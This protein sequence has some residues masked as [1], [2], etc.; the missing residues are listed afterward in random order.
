MTFSAG[1]VAYGIADT[2]VPASVGG[3]LV[4]LAAATM[5][6]LAKMRAWA[7]DTSAERR[8]LDEAIQQATDERTRYIA[9]QSAQEEEHRRRLRD[10]E[11]DRARVQHQLTAAK[12]ALDEQF[13]ARREKL[14]V[15][16]METAIRL[17]LAGLL[18]APAETPDATILHLP[19]KQPVRERATAHPADPQLVR[20]REARHP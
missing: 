20:E 9:A 11:A 15:S 16:S 3:G 12:A 5:M 10:L 19:G 2:S 18:D 4:G 7:V 17:H 14:I 13:E 6:A 8:K 1:I